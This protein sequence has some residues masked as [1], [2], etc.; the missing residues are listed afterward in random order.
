MA[1]NTSKCNRLTSLRFKGLTLIILWTNNTTIQQLEKDVI[2]KISSEIIPSSWIL[3]FL[4]KR[5]SVC[6]E[7]M[8]QV[9]GIS[10]PEKTAHHRQDS[11]KCTGSDVVASSTSS[12]RPRNMSVLAAN[13]CCNREYC[14]PCWPLPEIL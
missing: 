14:W 7:D 13:R 12:R 1:L 5:Y 3:A 10:D 8:K 2:H 6:V 11:R 4:K 9:A